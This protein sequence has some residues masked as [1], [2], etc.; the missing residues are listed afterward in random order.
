MTGIL[1]DILLQHDMDRRP[2]E[3]AREYRMERELRRTLAAQFD[4]ES[5]RNPE[6]YRRRVRRF[7]LLL[8]IYVYGLIALVSGLWI[9]SIVKILTPASQDQDAPYQVAVLLGAALFLLTRSLFVKTTTPEGTELSRQEAPLLWAE[10]D[11]FV[12]EA[13]APKIDAIV[14]TMEANAVAAQAPAWG[15][16]GPTRSV[17]VIGLPLMIVLSPDE[18]RFVIAHELGHFAGAHG[19]FGGRVG[20]LLTRAYRLGT[21]YQIHQPFLRWYYRKL[22]VMSFSLRRQHEFEADAVA[23]RLTSPGLI[24]SILRL[25]VADIVLDKSLADLHK[26]AMKGEP[27]PASFVGEAIRPLSEPVVIDEALRGVI[28]TFREA[29]V[30]S[31]DTHPAWA[32]RVRSAGLNVPS[33]EECENYVASEVSA[34]AVD[35]FLGHLLPGLFARVE[36]MEYPELRSQW[37]RAIRDGENDRREEERLMGLPNR[38]LQEELDLL[39]FRR[40]SGVDMHAQYARVKAQNPDDPLA[41]FCYGMSLSD[42]EDPDAL[43]VLTRVIDMSADLAPYAAE[44]VIRL[45]RLRGNFEQDDLLERL[46]HAFAQNQVA[47]SKRRA[48]PDLDTRFAPTTLRPDQV[49]FISHKLSKLKLNAG[50]FLVSRTVEGVEQNIVIVIPPLFLP[51]DSTADH[52][53]GVVKKRLGEDSPRVL[54]WIPVHQPDKWRKKLAGL[55]F[56]KLL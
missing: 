42:R 56:G 22:D 52:L 49:E 55:G 32:D 19:K 28:R 13:S 40:R 50:V 48:A 12:L 30:D 14:I 39:H 36:A 25:R 54:I 21:A 46:D 45:R 53:I 8:D 23:A 24:L 43:E 29:P 17:L 38:T 5:Q 44:E 3:L 6:D 51:T 15:Y 9:L 16:L 1:S 35:H 2:A 20:R 41:N 27:Q 11:R 37:A 4:A 26:L 34:R 7:A 33:L 31:E 10:V 47:E 18:A